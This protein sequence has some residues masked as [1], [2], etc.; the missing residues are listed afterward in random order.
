M[1]CPICE[2]DV[3]R[4]YNVSLTGYSGPLCAECLEWEHEKEDYKK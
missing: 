4:L 1:K 3:Y 2:R